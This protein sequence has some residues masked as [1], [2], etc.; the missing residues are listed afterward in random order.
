[1]R[2]KLKEKKKNTIIALDAEKE[3]DKDPTPLHDNKS[4]GQ[5]RDTGAYLNIIKATYSKPIANIK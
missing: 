1:M 3:F 5:S 2:K 4:L